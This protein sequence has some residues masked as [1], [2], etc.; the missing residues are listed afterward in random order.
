MERTTGGGLG[1]EISR[2]GNNIRWRRGGGGGGG[3]FASKAISCME[4][5]ITCI[6]FLHFYRASRVDE[7]W[8][9]KIPYRLPQNWLGGRLFHSTSTAF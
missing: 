4:H 5:P 7:N 2:L 3:G 9:K 8:F 6:I 1:G